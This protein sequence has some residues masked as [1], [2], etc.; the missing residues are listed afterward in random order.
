MLTR[1]K[2]QQGV[3]SMR[4]RRIKPIRWWGLIFLLSAMLLLT[5]CGSLSTGK[6]TLSPAPIPP[7]TLLTTTE[8]YDPARYHAAYQVAQWWEALGL[9]VQVV[10]LEFNDLSN[11][12][13]NHYPEDKHWDAFMMSWTGRVERGDPD[14]FIYSISH[15]SQA[16]VMGNNYYEYRNPAY[17]ALAEAQRRVADPEVR[18]YVVHEAQEVLARDIPFVTLYYRYVIQAYRSDLWENINT[19]TGEGIYHEWLPFHA[20]RVEPESQHPSPVRLIIASNQE[21]DSLNP[22]T[23]STVWEWKLLRFMYDKLARV[24]QHFQPEPWAALEINQVDDLTVEVKLREGMHFHDGM[25]VKP[26]DVLFTFRYMKEHNISYFNAFLQPID[27]VSLL[28]DG[29]IR[30][31]LKEPYAPFVTMTLAQIP[32]LPEHQWRH[33]LEEQGVE[34]PSQ[35]QKVPLVGSGPLSFHSWEPGQVIRFDRYEDYFAAR[36]IDMESL[37]YRLYPDIEGVFQAVMAG[38]AHMT[39][40]N[41]EPAHIE[42]AK[43][44]GQVT[45]VQVPDIGFHYLGF[46][47]QKPPFNDRAFREAAARAMDL[48]YLVDAF[49]QGYGDV[50]G[51]GQSIST[52]NPFW[53]NPEVT[54]YPYDLVAAREVLAAAGYSWDEAGRLCQ[55]E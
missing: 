53:R 32:I 40:V 11:T 36:D 20:D 47:N 22:M 31:Q 1:G 27:K 33:L 42:R 54:T 38:E 45:L 29:T 52:G 14:M 44:S 50:G 4:R 5:A 12:V 48:D 26:E 55:K 28:R 17:D 23:A 41:L 8:D 6:G 34:H 37:L 16:G 24:N 10:P 43:A 46:N 49:L 9:T 18:R 21:P 39:G 51:A 19:M 35:L 25:P 7:L 2:A 15:S 13:R 3:V 30:F